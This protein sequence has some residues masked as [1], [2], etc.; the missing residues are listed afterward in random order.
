MARAPKMAAVVVASS[1]LILTSCS[2]SSNNAG[3]S[4]STTASAPATSSVSASAAI[5]SSASSTSSGSTGAEPAYAAQTAAVITKIMK[6]N[7]IPGA[8][9][10]I[11]SPSKGDW[12]AT[13]GTGTVG[14][15][16]PITLDDYFRIGSNTKTMTSTVILQLAQEGKLSLDDP[17]AKYRPGVPNGDNIT[18]AQL[19][20]MRSGLYNYS[21]DPAFNA[22]L[23]NNPQK[24]W[25]PDELLA[26]AF[27]HPIGFQPGAQFDY[28]NTNIVLL[29]LVIEQLT[30]MPAAEAF[31]QR[32][33]TP[34]KM[35]HTSLP[36]STDAS[37][38]EP[39]PQGYMFGTNVS[40]LAD[41][42]LPPAEQTAAVAG[43]LKPNDVTDANPSWTW[44]AGGGI[45]TVDDLAVY[46]KALVGGG[47]LDAQMQKTRLDSI[48]P[49]DPAAPEVG[50]YGLGIARFGPSLIGHDGQIPGYMTFMG[51]DP[52]SDLTIVIAT[53]LYAIPSG[54]GAALQILKGLVP[55]FYGPG[56]EVPGNPAA[57]PGETSGAATSTGG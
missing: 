43:T 7:A 32:I 49:T 18:I 2:S 21:L 41:A 12:S 10:V 17:I 40:T 27:A 5:S 22:T 31:Q 23:D 47:L 48:V 52:A 16:D 4:S 24:A 39:H 44:T 14:R 25:T 42:A 9:V 36:A 45:S 13:F 57:A 53:N 38:R 51:Y 3:S 30:G 56:T 33:F 6:D 26:I 8:A 37:I 11:K 1:M 55:I 46:V 20:E 29:G 50:G 54:E 35:S 15:D 28:S 34:L 19:S